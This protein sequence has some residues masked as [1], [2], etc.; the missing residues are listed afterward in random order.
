[1]K[2]LLKVDHAKYP[3]E[4]IRNKNSSLNI[5]QNIQL[6]PPFRSVGGLAAIYMYNV[7]RLSLPRGVTTS[8]DAVI[9]DESRKNNYSVDQQKSPSGDALPRHSRGVYVCARACSAVRWMFSSD[10]ALPTMQEDGGT[11]AGR[12]GGTPPPPD[13]PESLARLRLRYSLNAFRPSPRAQLAV[14]RGSAALRAVFDAIDQDRS[15]TLDRREVES[16]LV[17]VGMPAPRARAEAD[18]MVRACGDMRGEISF[19]QVTVGG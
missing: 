15:G 9:S 19:K 12:A 2:C 14:A 16:A 5:Q 11:A 10:G 6:P 8:L 17:C 4:L 3:T 18:A 13:D 7:G 1:M